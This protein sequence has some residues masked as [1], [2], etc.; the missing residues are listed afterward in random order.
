MRWYRA[1]RAVREI[2]QWREDKR[3][4]GEKRVKTKYVT[5]I[6]LNNN[7][8]FNNSFNNNNRKRIKSSFVVANP[9]SYK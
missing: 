7:N 3:K 1:Q 6:S 2:L 4:G 8:N 5:N 9:N